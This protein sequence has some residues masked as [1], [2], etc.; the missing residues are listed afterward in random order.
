MLGIFIERT[1]NL[2]EIRLYQRE[3]QVCQFGFMIDPVIEGHVVCKIIQV[4][5]L[6]FGRYDRTGHFADVVNAFLLTL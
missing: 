6:L 4:T 5:L 3:I 1:S 2:F